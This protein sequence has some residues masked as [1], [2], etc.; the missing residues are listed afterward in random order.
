M[1]LGYSYLNTQDKPQFGRIPAFAGMTNSTA[2]D[3]YLRG[4]QREKESGDPPYVARI[5]L[6]FGLCSTSARPSSS[7]TGGT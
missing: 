4:L 3:E 1:M 5:R 7:K 6:P 2:D